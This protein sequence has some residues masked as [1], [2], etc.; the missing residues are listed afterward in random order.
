MGD[1]LIALAIAAVLLVFRFLIWG[2]PEGKW[3]E[4]T[5]AAVWRRV[6]CAVVPRWQRFAAAVRARFRRRSR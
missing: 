5:G 1:F 3:I 6:T 4:K 2:T